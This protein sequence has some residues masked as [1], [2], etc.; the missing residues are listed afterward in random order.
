MRGKS[1]AIL[2]SITAAAAILGAASYAGAYSTKLHMITGHHIAQELR[3]G[4]KC[5]I[6]LGDWSKSFA[7]SASFR[8][9]VGLAPNATIGKVVKLNP[10]ICSLITNPATSQYFVAATTGP[11][12]F[13]GMFGN[14]DPTHA[15]MWNTAWQIP[16]LWRNA[17]TPQEKAFVLGWLVHFAGDVNAHGLANMHAHGVWMGSTTDDRMGTVW[18]HIVTE[19]YYSKF[20]TPYPK[21]FDNRL[22]WPEAFVK[23]MFFNPN[24]PLYQHMDYLW[25]RHLSGPESDRI[26]MVSKIFGAVYRTFFLLWDY[27]GREYHRWRGHTDF[28]RPKKNASINDYLHWLFADQAMNLHKKK[29]TAAK[30][31]IDRWYE[32][33]ARAQQAIVADDDAKFTGKV[34]YDK[35]EMVLGKK[36]VKRDYFKAAGIGGL[37]D[38]YRYLWNAISEYLSPDV[39][40]ITQDNFPELRKV[41]D[42]LKA[43]GAALVAVY[44]GVRNALHA[45]KEVLLWPFKAIGEAIRKLVDPLLDSVKDYFA[46]EAMCSKMGQMCKTIR[47]QQ[48]LFRVKA[49]DLSTYMNWPIYRNTIV[50]AALMLESLQKMGNRGNE[51]DSPMFGMPS[52]D[53]GCTTDCTAVYGANRSLFMPMAG[54]YYADANIA[55]KGP[56]YCMAGDA[57]R[58]SDAINEF[59]TGMTNDKANGGFT[60]YERPKAACR[61]DAYSPATKQPFTGPIGEVLNKLVDHVSGRWSYM[62]HPFAGKSGIAVQAKGDPSLCYQALTF[63]P[64]SVAGG[65]PNPDTENAKMYQVKPYSIREIIGDLF[66]PIADFVKSTF[67]AVASWVQDKVKAAAAA[68]VDTAR[69]TCQKVTQ[70]VEMGLNE[71]LNAPALAACRGICWAKAKS[72]KMCGIV[73]CGINH[74]DTKY[75]NCVKAD[76]RRTKPVEIEVCK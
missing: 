32:A 64:E 55:S 29:L 71:L 68:V 24:S 70:W 59:F 19:T 75:Q 9:A 73:P 7:P 35:V 25:N 58:R 21:G 65:L 48:A 8:Q 42:S 18:K 37:V 4:G 60:C 1:A 36:V 69:R 53:F 62:T 49:G 74:D 57:A 14:T 33:T 67:K 52:G 11:D 44:Q 12:T 20:M 34:G 28:Y 10:T 47:D 46:E 43:A 22:L 41:L 23:K 66:A 6:A 13:P 38:A 3:K 17:V 51:T 40:T 27:H 76:C 39:I 45:L 61:A 26:G 30:D 50:A 5:Q 54:S 63:G 56:D 31:V 15:L 2:S 16:V 72:V